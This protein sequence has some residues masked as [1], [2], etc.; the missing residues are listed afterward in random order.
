MRALTCDPGGRFSET[1]ACEKEPFLPC[2][3]NFKSYDSSIHRSAIARGSALPRSAA[4]LP[5][6]PFPQTG[7]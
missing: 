6:A 5:R 1:A 3:A 4:L 7:H 2:F